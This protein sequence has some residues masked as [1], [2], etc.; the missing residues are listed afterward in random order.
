ML[1]FRWV[2][3]WE[4]EGVSKWNC[5]S[6]TC[7]SIPPLFQHPP[8]VRE[9]PAHIPAAGGDLSASVYT[10][11]APPRWAAPSS[12]PQASAPSSAP[13]LPR[14]IGKLKL[15]SPDRMTLSM[16]W[17]LTAAAQVSDVGAPDTWTPKW[18]NWAEGGRP[19]PRV[20]LGQTY[21]QWTVWAKAGGA[22]PALMTQ[23]PIPGWSMGLSP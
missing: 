1:P 14:C 6:N 3:H 20:Q 19:P 23:L 13:L 8:Q 9:E 16:F 7:V 12:I 15:Y 5:I 2:S 10:T 4:N 17:R 22:K 18:G 11:M 21:T